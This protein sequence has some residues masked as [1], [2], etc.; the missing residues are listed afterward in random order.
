[1]RGAQV[2]GS[3]PKQFVL[4][5]RGALGLIPNASR[6]GGEAT[7]LER[8]NANAEPACKLKYVIKITC[9]EQTLELG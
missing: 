3:K 4:G 7:I 1:M 2:P 9:S 6:D 5:G 8:R